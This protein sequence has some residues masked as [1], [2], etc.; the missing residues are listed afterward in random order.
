[1]LKF[2]DIA[3]VHV[4][5]SPD[6]QRL[7]AAGRETGAK[8][9]EVATSR[10]VLTM[11]ALNGAVWDINYSP[12]GKY[13]VTAGGNKTAKVWDA[14]TGEEL[15]N[16]QMPGSVARAFFTPDERAVM[17]AVSAAGGPPSLR[18]NAFNFDDLVALARSRLLRDWQPGECLKYLHAETCPG[19]P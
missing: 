17:M 13:L 9:W 14:Q 19:R 2:G 16:Y 11:T 5:F 15:L 3:A 4:N 18:L 7:A 6:G 10:A 1:V 8:V 12:D